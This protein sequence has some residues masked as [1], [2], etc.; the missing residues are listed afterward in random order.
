MTIIHEWCILEWRVQW[1]HFTSLR[2]IGARAECCQIWLQIKDF[3]EAVYACLALPWLGFVCFSNYSLSR[4]LILIYFFSMQS[5]YPV[6]HRR[7]WQSFKNHLKK[8]VFEKHYPPLLV[9]CECCE[10]H[11]SLHISWVKKYS[12]WIWFEKFSLLL[13]SLKANSH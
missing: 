1:L 8:R 7:T 9:L 11:L 3:Y 5:F 4:F 13:C 10:Q 6:S 12:E 2:L